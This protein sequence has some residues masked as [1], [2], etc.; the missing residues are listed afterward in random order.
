[1]LH[2]SQ[3]RIVSQRASQYLSSLCQQWG[4]LSRVLYDGKQGL[5]LDPQ[6]RRILKVQG[7][8]LDI[9]LQSYDLGV[10]GAL[11]H[12]VGNQLGGLLYQDAQAIN[13]SRQPPPQL[14]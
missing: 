7:D 9:T 3:T 6:S 10:L 11:E 2:I 5:V 4:R 14:V 13:W 12:N 1:M 8:C